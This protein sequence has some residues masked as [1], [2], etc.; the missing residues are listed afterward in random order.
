ML[1]NLVFQGQ[2]H[3]DFPFTFKLFITVNSVAVQCF[4]IKNNAVLCKSQI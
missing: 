2:I 3:Q 4:K 1:I